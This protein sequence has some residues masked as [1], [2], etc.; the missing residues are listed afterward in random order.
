MTKS[1]SYSVEE[2]AQAAEQAR[3]LAEVL[4]LLSLKN[5]GGRR[6]SVRRDLDAHGIETSHFR[7]QAWTK[8]S[9]DVLSEAVAKSTSINEVLDHLGIPR[10]GGSHT[11]ISRR[12]KSA[13]INT[14]HFSHDLAKPIG[15]YDVIEPVILRDAAEGARSMADILTRLCLPRTPGALNDVRR[16]LRTHGIEEPSNYRRLEIDE[17]RI[18]QVVASCSS[19]ADVIRSLNLPVSETNR[20]RILRHIAT[21]MIDTSHFRRAPASMVLSQP[22]RNPQGVLVERPAGSSRTAGTRL[23]RA[24]ISCGVRP[25]CASCGLEELW[26]GRPLNLEVDHINGN[27]LDNRRENLRLLCPNCH[28]Q[29]ETFA[30]RNRGRATNLTSEKYGRGDSNP[31]G[32][33]TSET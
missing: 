15:A 6:S 5:S 29:T 9:P 7:R 27:P 31:H 4:K 13:D 10:R 19:V 26:R 32:V 22:M 8:Y 20:R 17:P 18:R 30:G 12:I 24:S 11:H 21:Y 33:S 28:S 23:R 3:S 1:P 25:N 2:L 14:D 16:Q